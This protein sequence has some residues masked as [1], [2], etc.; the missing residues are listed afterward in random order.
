VSWTDYENH[1]KYFT[2]LSERNLENFK[3]D[4]KSPT[5]E[6]CPLIKQFFE[7]RKSDKVVEE[8][9]EMQQ[10]PNIIHLSTRAFHH[11]Q[12]QFQT[13]GRTF[14]FMTNP[15]KTL[16]K[17]LEMQQFSWLDMDDSGKQRADFQEN[18]ILMAKVT[19]LNIETDML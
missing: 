2:Y 7:R 1:T 14:H 16:H 3:H 9:G 10:F 13:Q 11:R 4:L 18:L 15:N 19:K 6:Y 12:N 5:L 8:N 17:V